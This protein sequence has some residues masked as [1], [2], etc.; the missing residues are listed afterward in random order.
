M[1][2]ME[3]AFE[4]RSTMTYSYILL[5]YPLLTLLYTYRIIRIHMEYHRIKGR[6]ISLRFAEL[7][8]F[9]HEILQRLRVAVLNR[10]ALCFALKRR[11]TR[12]RAQCKSSLIGSFWLAEPS[13]PLSTATRPVEPASALLKRLRQ[14]VDLPN[15]GQEQEPSRHGLFGRQGLRE[16]S[17]T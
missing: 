16:A 4:P 14:A 12:W 1:S 7:L 3:P 17:R 5:L 6:N 8:V 11:L 10:L 2:L 15:E 9:L 13:A